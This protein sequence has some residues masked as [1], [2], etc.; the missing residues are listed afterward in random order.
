MRNIAND[1]R[2]SFDEMARQSELDDLRK[3]VEEMRA[4]TAGLSGDPAGIGQAM[5]DFEMTSMNPA[6]DYGAPSP[7]LQPVAAKPKRAP[8]KKP[9]TAKATVAKASAAS[10]KKKTPAKPKASASKD[11]VQ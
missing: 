8:R 6:P 3:Q 11:I 5:Q 2:T 10:A 1:F 9:V 4:Q 7:E